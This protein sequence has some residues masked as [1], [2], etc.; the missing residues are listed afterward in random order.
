M[1]PETTPAL[2]AAAWR[3]QRAQARHLAEAIHKAIEGLEG[4]APRSQIV[5]D[6][7]EALRDA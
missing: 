2:Y 7:Q 6:L 3:E 1:K 4:D 5:A